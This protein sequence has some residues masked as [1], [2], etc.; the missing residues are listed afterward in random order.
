MRTRNET[1]APVPI[2]IRSESSK[3]YYSRS[4]G[5]YLGVL[6]YAINKWWTPAYSRETLFEAASDLQEKNTR[7]TWNKFEHYRRSAT[8]NVLAGFPLG[9]WYYPASSTYYQKVYTLPAWCLAASPNFVEAFGSLSSPSKG[10]PSLYKV[11][12]YGFIPDPVGLNTLIGHSLKAMLPQIK[13][14]LSLPNSIYELKD[15][16]GLVRNVRKLVSKLDVDQVLSTWKRI[17]RIPG[18]LKRGLKGQMT[19][20]QIT[21]G[22][23]G[24]YLQAEFNILPTL[25]DISA[26]QNALN[27]VRKEVEKLLSCEAKRLT[28]HFTCEL[29]D[30]SD[31]DQR[32]TGLSMPYITFASTPGGVGVDGKMQSQTSDVHRYAE[33]EIAQFHA[34]IEYSYY[35]SQFQREHAMLLGLLDKLGVN[36][37]P[38]IIWNAIPWSFVVD[39]VLGV[40]RWLDQFKLSNMEP[41]TIIH[42]YLWSVT[43][44]RRLTVDFSPGRGYAGIGNPQTRIV[45]VVEEAYKRAPAQLTTSNITASGVSLKEFSLAGALAISRRR[46]K[47]RRH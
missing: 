21:G 39:W 33:Y 5:A 47:R 27:N 19:L 38:S 36:L 18:H 41:L 15:Y 6:S 37:N 23:A 7:S 16:R 31:Y 35:L 4:T 20:A 44:K 3:A 29:G 46:V 40:N 9:S 10:L 26:V 25:S 12:E 42:R 32:V 43:I 2:N 22:G 34:E 17:K 45:Q 8:F 1:I 13:P 11:D 14:E 28:R 24:A 30:Y